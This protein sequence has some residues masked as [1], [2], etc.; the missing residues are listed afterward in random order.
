[1]S[2]YLQTHRKQ[3]GARSVKRDAST[4]NAAREVSVTR[5]ASELKPWLELANL[6]ERVGRIPDDRRPLAL[7]NVNVQGLPE[8]PSNLEPAALGSW[9]ASEILDKFEIELRKLLSRYRAHQGFPTDRVRALLERE[10]PKGTWLVYELGFNV[11]NALVYATRWH[12]SLGFARALGAMSLHRLTWIGVSIDHDGRFRTR[13]DDLFTDD[14]LKVFDGIEVVSFRR[15]KDRRV[16][17]RIRRCPVCPSL[18]YAVRKDKP[19]CSSRCG[20]ILRTRNWLKDR[21]RYEATRK[22]KT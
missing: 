16:E 2:T 5:K 20:H 7:R 1:M 8:L 10:K 4:A 14:F 13:S 15:G 21:E 19:A 22:S 9:P 18:F 3:K 11:R 6:V 17:P 12:P